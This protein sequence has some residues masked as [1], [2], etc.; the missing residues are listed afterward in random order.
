[1]TMTLSGDGSI[2]G[3]I[4]GG[5]PNATIQTADIVDGAVTAAKIAGGV[6][7]GNLTQVS[8]QV[9]PLATVGTM[10]SYAHGLGVIPAAVELEIVCVTAELGYAV[11]DV[12][13]PYTSNGTY[14]VPITIRKTTTLVTAATQTSWGANHATT[15][16]TSAVNLANW[17]YRF[18]VR[19]A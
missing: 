12:T 11:G 18:K 1:M 14:A 8:S 3:L 7:A 10:I 2:T 5:L 15:G 16:V 6:G 13:N 19:A 4:A 17:A 9:T